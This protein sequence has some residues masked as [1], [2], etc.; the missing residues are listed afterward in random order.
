MGRR[1]LLRSSE[2][3]AAAGEELAARVG[4]GAK[5]LLVGPLGA[6]KT[7]LVK[8]LCRGLGI[9]EDVTSP[10]FTIVH[11][12]EAAAGFVLHHVDLYRIEDPSELEETGFLEMWD[13]PD[14]VVVEWGDRLPPELQ[15]LAHLRVSLEHDG[16]GRSMEVVGRRGSLVPGGR[17]RRVAS[18]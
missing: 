2:E 9:R 16:E 12:Y 13:G 7:T 10:T 1:V 17:P 6:G 14:A 15:R 18:P 8:G 11:Q 5:L 3:T 4:P